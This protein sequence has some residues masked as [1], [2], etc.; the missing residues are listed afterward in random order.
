MHATMLEIHS[1]SRI[2]MM[3]HCACIGKVNIAK[4]VCQELEN[5][6]KPAY[7]QSMTHIASNTMGTNA[8]LAIEDGKCIMM[9]VSGSGDHF[10][11]LILY[12]INQI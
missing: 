6:Q 2:I 3:T 11:L 1:K 9:N 7:A 4:Y 10:I 5:Q 12:N 8:W